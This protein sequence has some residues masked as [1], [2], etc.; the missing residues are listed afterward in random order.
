[1]KYF[2]TLACAILLSC[3]GGGGSVATGSNTG[4]NS[5]SSSTPTGVSGLGGSISNIEIIDID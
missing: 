1:M 5:N 2:A 4:S 3:G